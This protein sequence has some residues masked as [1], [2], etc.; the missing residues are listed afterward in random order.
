MANRTSDENLGDDL[1]FYEVEG[2][3]LNPHECCSTNSIRCLHTGPEIPRLETPGRTVNQ[4][5]WNPFIQSRRRQ[6]P[7][8]SSLSEL[9]RDPNSLQRIELIANGECADVLLKTDP[10]TGEKIAVKR[11]KSGAF[12]EYSFRREIEA[13]MN[14]VHPCVLRIVGWCPRLST[15]R[16]EIWTEYGPNKSLDTVFEKVSDGKGPKFWNA[17]GKAI[18]ICGIALG[19]RHVHGRG[20]IHRDLKPSNILIDADGHAL[21]GGFG[22]VISQSAGNPPV[23]EG[24]TLRYAAP[25]MFQEEDDAS[26]T[27]KVD[28]FSFG[29]ILY[30]ILTWRCVF[31]PDQAPLSIV[32]LVTNGEMPDV[33]D[34]CGRMKDVIERC[35][36]MNPDDRPSFDSLIDAFMTG[37][38]DI[39]PGANLERVR[40]YVEPLR[41]WESPTGHP[42][43]R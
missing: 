3:H 32:S 39:V 35:W 29:S 24:A 36:S 27:A 34:T 40:E 23:S 19:M 15:S 10:K 43:Y 30:E 12:S 42:G 4:V 6:Q 2:G 33:P 38:Y 37:E 22:T 26:C 9:R 13:M 5:D 16:A 18:I 20:Y 21:I 17:T 11:I 25:E 31:S 1:A 8:P 28:V 7:P 14:L 41:L